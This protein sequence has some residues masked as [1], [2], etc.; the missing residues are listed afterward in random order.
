[1]GERITA[2]MPVKDFDE[3]HYIFM[4]TALGTV[5]KTPLPQFSRPRSV[6]LRAIELDEGDVLVGTAITDGSRDVIL[7]ASNGKAARFGEAQVRSMGRISRG[8]RG[9]RLEEGHK[10]ISMVIP[11]QDGKV[12]TVS[13]TGYG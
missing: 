2:V 3:N 7:F 13:E 4:A 5:K 9:I 12:L 8:V 6:G 11:Q 1:E 10:V